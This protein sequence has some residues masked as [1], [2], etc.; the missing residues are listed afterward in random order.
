MS[1]EPKKEESRVSGKARARGEY[2]GATG[3]RCYQMVMA[4][5]KKMAHYQPRSIP[6]TARRSR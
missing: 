4:I 3:E 5:Y 1:A 2:P 6:T